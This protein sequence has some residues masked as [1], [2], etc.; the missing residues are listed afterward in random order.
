MTK[1][2]FILLYIILAIWMLLLGSVYMYTLYRIPI[3]NT[4]SITTSISGIP[5]MVSLGVFA[6]GMYWTSQ[7]VTIDH[8]KRY[9]FLGMGLF[10]SGLFLSAWMPNLIVFTISY[11][12]MMGFGVGALYGIALMIVSLQDIKQKGLFS[13]LMLFAFGASSALLSPFA[14]RFII[15]YNIQTLF[16]TYGAIALVLTVILTLV[17]LSMKKIEGELHK[18][19]SKPW[20]MM[21]ILMAMMTLISLTLIGLT[22]KIAID[23]Y[24]YDPIEVSLIVS[25]FALSNALARPLFGYLSDRIGFR[26][27]AYV[28]LIL[29]V[30]ATII[31]VLSQGKYPTLFFIGYGIYWFNLGIWLAL[32]P[33]LVL[34]TYGK[35]HYTK[36]YGKV[37]LGYGV[38]A[39]IGTLISGYV[40]ELLNSPNY[41]YIL[42]GLVV[43]PAYV[44][45]QK[46]SQQ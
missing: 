20:I 32:M 22:G 44:M 41:V 33:L 7:H 35:N 37:Y 45:I 18:G 31:N 6:V 43:I 8:I 28:S 5:Y 4:L 39:I 24:N 23:F 1:K 30:I 19:Q 9:A 36:T 12:I 42:F 40:L 16:L 46:I 38:G 29:I 21:F 3:E 17:L 14:A 10:T 27:S 2:T 26:K 15:T 25:L 34:K 11:G 13:G